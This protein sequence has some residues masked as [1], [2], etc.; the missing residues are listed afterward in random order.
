MTIK[1]AINELNENF[2]YKYTNIKLGD[3][4]HL[5]Q[6]GS[7]NE[8]GRNLYNKPLE[9]FQGLDLFGGL[10]YVKNSSLD[11]LVG[12]QMFS[13]SNFDLVY[14]E[15]QL[16]VKFFEGRDFVVESNLGDYT[17]KELSDEDYYGSHL[18]HLKK[19]S[20]NLI[21]NYQ[22][23]QNNEILFQLV[24]FDDDDKEE[25]NYLIGVPEIIDDGF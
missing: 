2:Y 4:P 1:Q 23:L 20:L 10:Y 8:N 12:V 25:F 18:V 16:L 15:T 5:F 13:R 9:V 11:K 19:N 21:I 3:F 17:R 14:D 6:V 7:T 22:N 24:L